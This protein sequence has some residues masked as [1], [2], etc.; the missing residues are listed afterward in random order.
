[1]RATSSLFLCLVLLLCGCARARP[2]VSAGPAEDLRQADPP[3]GS[4]WKQGMA[5]YYLDRRARNVGDIVTVKVI[6]ESTASQ[7]ASTQT[8][9]SSDIDA[10]LEDTFG[11]PDDY[12][13][14]NF[15]S[16]GQ[17]FSPTFKGYYDRTFQ[18]GGTT[19]RKDKL[20]S[21]VTASI[22]EKLPGGN[23][24]IEAKREIKI[25]RE[26]QNVTLSG[27]IRPEDISAFNTILSTQ[28]ADAQIKY[29]GKGVL[30]DTQGQG[31]FVRLLDWLWPI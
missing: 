9:R 11:L 24:R 30:G 8:G 23:L 20:V 19:V 13:M 21:T 2:V 29:T 31:W 14:A 6:E 1:M 4:I 16:S 10:A 27:I 5:D 25:N 17:S 15:L 22:V 26:K 18:G 28:I 7:E 3:S 12:G